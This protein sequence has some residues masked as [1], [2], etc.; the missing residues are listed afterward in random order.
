MAFTNNVMIVRHGLLAKLVRMWKDDR[1]V[2]DI[3]HLPNQL[4]P[5]KSKVR[6]RCC[7]YKERAVYKYKMMPLLGFDMEDEE[8]ELTPLSY[9]A[10][11]ALKRKENTKKNILCVM[12]EACSSCVQVNYEI[13][14]LCRGCVA[15]SCMMNCPKDCIEF[16]KD[17][18]AQINHEVC[19]SCGLCMKYCPYHAINFI[20]VPCEEAC[21]VG[22]ISKDDWGV[23]HIDE[24]KC[25]YCGKCMNACPF[26]A[27]FEIS[28]VFDIL[29]HVRNPE[30]KVVA[31][32]A[33]AIR[34]QY[35]E[36]VEVVYGA[37]HKIG[38]DDVIEVAQGAM[39]TTEN[40]AKELV[41]KL[42][43]G[44]PFMTTSCCPSYVE[45]VKKHVPELMKYVSDTRSPM[46]YTAGL[47]RE[48]YPDAKLVFVGP[49]IG[50]RKEALSSP[51]VDYV[52]TFEEISAVFTGLDIEINHTDG[53]KVA[54]VGDKD[55]QGYAQAGGVAQAVL[56]KI[57]TP[58]ITAQSV[59]N[60]DRK[61][62]SLLKS[63]A[64]KG[65]APAQLLE[66]MACED[67]CISGPTGHTDKGFAVRNF[68]KHMRDL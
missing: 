59:A 30:Q 37:I 63:W 62:I 53:Y 26:G 10:A 25:I 57:G 58:A 12:D 28:Q 47:A 17:G 33:P 67:G 32:V 23:E 6:G 64:K 43:E 2:E 20:P 65:E 36:K 40:E 31:L 51:E 66:V 39:T 14:N 45:A 5:R 48:K 34:S 9:Y 44:Q 11:E 27:I 38:F 24:D 55:A 52:M 60:I 54:V 13:S 50:K 22:A 19:I 18:K 68:K 42:S 35:K 61:T 49:C 1:L 3:D 29:E 7:V 46:Y 15:R 21:P 56:N 4:S 41:H 8:D 16:T